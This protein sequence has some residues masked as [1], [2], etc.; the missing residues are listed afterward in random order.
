M[1]RTICVPC[2]IISL[3]AGANAVAGPEEDRQ[4][5]LAYYTD[6]FPEVPLQE[7]ANGLYAF[8]EDAR[9]QWIEIE[10]FPPYEIAIEDGQLLFETPFA[11][12]NSYADCFENNGIGVRQQYPHF[13]SDLG[14]VMTLE[15]AIN[16]CREANDEKPLPFLTG[17]LAA[18]SAYM[19]YTSRGN[20]I[21]V[22]VPQD[23][24]AAMAAYEA[25]KQYFYTRRGQL[26][27]ACTSCHLQSAGL[28]LRAD[29]L[30]TTLGQATH[31][32]VYRAKWGEIGTLQNRITECNSQ[33]FAK[34]LEAQSLEYRNL[35]Y[36]L[37]YMSNGLELNG[38]ATRR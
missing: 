24:A 36:F 18:I 28:M 12:G 33:V 9:E 15:L 30:S 32:P 2:I 4:A 35:E 13:D 31:W 1:I 6:R 23:N 5:M 25:G 37:T 14:E 3:V 10:D 11:N 38:P 21:D 7:F 34:P 26:N 22:Q 29:R 17:D 8:D 19:S 16:R 27:F 20:I